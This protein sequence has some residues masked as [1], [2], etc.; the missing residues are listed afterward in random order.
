M[1]VSKMQL[2]VYVGIDYYKCLM[3]GNGSNA[4][5]QE[6]GKPNGESSMTECR[7]T[8]QGVVDKR[9]LQVISFA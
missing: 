6:G 1:H 4:R 7:E 8:E 5:W 3:S 9:G 2:V